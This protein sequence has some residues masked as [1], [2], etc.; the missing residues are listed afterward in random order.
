M[1]RLAID[2][3][4]FG[5]RRLGEPDLAMLQAFCEANPDYFELCDDAPPDPDCAWEIFAASAPG[6]TADEKALIGIFADAAL[7]GA[8]ELQQ[9]Y[10]V[11][12]VWMLAWFI[13]DQAWCGR[14]LGRRLERAVGEAV[15]RQGGHTLPI[16]VVDNNRPALA[17][18]PRL[19]Y[20]TIGHKPWLRGAIEDSVH[21]MIRELHE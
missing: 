13:I 4:S 10:P 3:P 1:S 17:F 16:A 15:R 20:R 14:G 2:L 21:I 11:E 12:G 8:A 9:D 5:C 6:H 18:W 7:I 19:G